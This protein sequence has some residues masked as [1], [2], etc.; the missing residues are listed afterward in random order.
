[1]SK[2]SCL[3]CGLALRANPPVAAAIATA[4]LSSTG[5]SR[6]GDTEPNSH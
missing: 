5:F 4:A 3:H 6:Y 1:M 2:F